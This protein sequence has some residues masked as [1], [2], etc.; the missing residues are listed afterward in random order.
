MKSIS[1]F[2]AILALPFG[3]LAAQAR[4]EDPDR[5]KI[6]VVSYSVQAELIPEQHKLNGRAEIRFK[7][8]DRKPFAVFDIDRRLRVMDVTVN[9]AKARSR[10]TD[11]DSTLEIDL[12][13]QQ[14]AAESVV[15]IDYSGILNPEDDRQDEILARV[16][17]NST[18]LLYDAKWFPTNGLYSDPA[19]FSLRLT[20]PP[21]WKVSTDLRFAGGAYVSSQPGFWGTIAAGSYNAI[22]VQSEGVSVQMQLLA[23]KPETA[24][25]L[26][27]TAA[28]MLKYYGEKFGPLGTEP[29][30]IL[31]VEGANW[32]A[33]SSPRALFLA[34]NEIRPDFDAW[35]LGRYLA[36]QWFPFRFPVRSSGDAWLADGMANFASLMFF[37]RTLSPAEAQEYLEKA[38]VKALAY[39]GKATIKEAGA[40]PKDSP[41]YRALVVFKGG[42][43]LRMLQWVIGDESFNKLMTSFAET[44]SA[45]PVTTEAFIELAREAAGGDISYFFDQWINSS[46]VPEFQNEY[47]VLRVRDGYKVMGQLKQDLDLFRMP[48]ELQVQTDSDPEYFRVDVSG[49]SSDFDIVAQRKPKAI[50]IDPRRRILRL[51]DDIKVAV[52]V[53]RGEEFANDGKYNQA[54]D[55]YQKAV[56]L[57]KFSSLALFRM[58]EA[59]FELGNLQAAAQTFRESLNGDLKPKWVEVW[60]YLNLGKIYDIRGQRE[61]AVTEYQ[62]AVNT[63][64]DAYG[65]QAEAQKYIQE[66]FRRSGKPTIGN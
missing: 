16:G 18:F 38:L 9:G 41:E 51:S 29:F 10:Q 43:V 46:G 56:D 11:I 36:E 53:N 65:A 3:L 21:S 5:P 50:L 40:L 15:R 61:R 30:Q 66:P 42:F 44:F 55:E 19:E 13:S 52:L 62:K 54:I 59:L 8:L 2:L 57:S 22:D 63:G 32:S 28:K 6:D 17:T 7:Q 20:A 37:E 60:A 12:S 35:V 1:A 64:E 26:G 48:V 25:K 58:G 45:T 27:E 23:A 24:Q 39:E 31:E 47:T 33:R 4:T 14:F 34:H 49:P